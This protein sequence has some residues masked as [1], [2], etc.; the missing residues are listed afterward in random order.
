MNPWCQEGRLV[1]GP[2]G[3][4]TVVVDT[5][6]GHKKIHKDRC[7]YQC[8]FGNFVH[9]YLQSLVTPISLRIMKIIHKVK[10]LG[11]GSITS[12]LDTVLLP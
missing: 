4:S 1:V 6:Y 7:K 12:L 5:P 2:C 8:L 3:P 11:C 10:Q 9:G